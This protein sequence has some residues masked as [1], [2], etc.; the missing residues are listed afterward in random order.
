MSG[1]TEKKLPNE[2]E[3]HII[4]AISEVRFG[5]VEVLIHDSKVVQVEKSEKTR[6]DCKKN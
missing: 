5:A 1:T 3:R 6:F 4:D 2:I